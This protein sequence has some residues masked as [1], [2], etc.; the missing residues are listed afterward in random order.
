MYVYVKLIHMPNFLL[1]IDL[2]SILALNSHLMPVNTQNNETIPISSIP[3]SNKLARVSILLGI[4]RSKV[5]VDISFYFPI[6]TLADL[7]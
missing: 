6:C 4:A 3:I 2:D 7:F 1:Q 5:M